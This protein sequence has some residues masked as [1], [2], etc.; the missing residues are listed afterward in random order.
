MTIEARLGG[1]VAP[2]FPVIAGGSR[3]GGGRLGGT[4]RLVGCR[5]HCGIAQGNIQDRGELG[6]IDEDLRGGEA[7]YLYSEAW[8]MIGKDT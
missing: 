1:T 2:A 3:V 8:R 6:G 7:L 5:R 4:S